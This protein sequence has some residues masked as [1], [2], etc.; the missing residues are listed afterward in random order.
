MGDVTLDEA[1]ARL[2]VAGLAVD[3]EW[4]EMVQRLLNEA[5]APLRRADARA[6]RTVEP[7]ATFDAAGNEGS[8]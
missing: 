2:A 6:L 8:R 7:A 3:D 1:R 4:L 5:L